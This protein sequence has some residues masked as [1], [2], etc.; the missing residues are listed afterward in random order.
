VPPHRR[1]WTLLPR[2]RLLVGGVAVF[3]YK[4]STSQGSETINE[5]SELQLFAI[6]WKL[7]IAIII[8]GGCNI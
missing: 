2:P 1:V 7:L 4:Y 5:L 6:T 8:A 3:Y